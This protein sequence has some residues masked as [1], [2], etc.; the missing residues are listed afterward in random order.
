MKK[1]SRIAGSIAVSAVFL[2]PSP[3][4]AQAN[5]A[6]NSNIYSDPQ[7]TNLVGQIF[8]VGCTSQNQ[9][10]YYLEGSSHGYAVDELQGHCVDGQMQWY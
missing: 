9:P 1:Y 7:H 8:W 4:S 2:V 3:A 5:P 10:Q 6:Y